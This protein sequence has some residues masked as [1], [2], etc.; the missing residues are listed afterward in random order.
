MAIGNGIKGATVS[1]YRRRCLKRA[2]TCMACLLAMMVTAASAQSPR[3]RILLDSDWRF[4]LGDASGSDRLQFDD[5]AWERIGLPHSFGIPYFGATRF[6][7]GY[8]WYRKHVPLKRL[9]PEQR[10]CIEF[11]A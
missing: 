6:Y 7:V 8:G 1:G 5:S 4:H 9:A 10:I 11:E 2:I 3:Q